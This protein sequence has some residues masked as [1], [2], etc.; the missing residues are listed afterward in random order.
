MRPRT[1]RKAHTTVTAKENLIEFMRARAPHDGL[2]PPNECALGQNTDWW[3]QASADFAA[4]QPELRV[5]RRADQMSQSARK[6][7]KEE[8]HIGE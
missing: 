8:E 3:N 1:Q 5:T 7:E 2:S 4:N 6:N